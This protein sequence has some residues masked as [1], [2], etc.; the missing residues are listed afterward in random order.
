M[1]QFLK[2]QKIISIPWECTMFPLASFTL[3]LVVT[4]IEMC[5]IQLVTQKKI[6]GIYETTQLKLYKFGRRSNH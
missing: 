2:L 6:H 1:E 5:D 4:N 3:A